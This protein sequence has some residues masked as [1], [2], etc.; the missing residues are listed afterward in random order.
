MDQLITGSASDRRGT[1]PPLLCLS[2]LRWDFV[3]QR[4]QH[5][6]T[7][8]AH[9]RRVFFWEEP[10]VSPEGGPHL[11]VRPTPQEVT[12]VTPVLPPDL[13][14]ATASRTLA[15]MLDRLI[16]AERLEKAVLWY[17]TP[18]ALTF[19]AHRAAS[20]RIVYDCMDELSAFLG[21]DPALPGRERALLDLAD[22][23]FTGG[24]SLYEAK[25]T[26]HHA[27]HPFPSGARGAF[28][29]RAR[30]AAR[31]GRP[32]APAAPQAGLL[33]RDR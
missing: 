31:P 33:R 19:S 24:Y 30:P 26:A 17:Y 14:A 15:Q 3:F 13:D 20:H 2:H 5:L 28:P 6:M 10:V 9:T 21:A 32:A 18:A 8:A 16:L 23:V 22:L 1:A 27:V 11:L 4:P 12:V 7:R 29:P 25:R